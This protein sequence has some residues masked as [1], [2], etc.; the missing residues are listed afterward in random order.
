MSQLITPA[1]ILRLRSLTNMIPEFWSQCTP[2]SRQQVDWCSSQINRAIP[3]ELV[4]FWTNIG[5]GLL[6]TGDYFDTPN[7][8]VAGC[9]GPLWMSIGSSGLVSDADHM[10]L[11]VT[12][13]EENAARNI[14]NPDSLRWEQVCLLDLLQIGSDGSGGY[15]LRYVGDNTP[16]S[17]YFLMTGPGS[18]ETRAASLAEGL[19]RSISEYIS[20]L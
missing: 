8:V 14:F 2:W 12:H 10:R 20:S 1:W 17:V 15:H 18:A 6:P 9:I 7:S 16:P 13:G 3:N 4:D 11:Y 5:S 19:S